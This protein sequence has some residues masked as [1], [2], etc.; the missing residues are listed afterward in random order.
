MNPHSPTFRRLGLRSGLVASLALLL[1]A[2]GLSC[3]KAKINPDK[4]LG[5]T[6]AVLLKEGESQLKRGRF[7]EG[8]RTLRLIEENLPSA[9]EFPSAKLLIA[10]SF[11]YGS[12]ASYPEAL[13]EYQSF[14]NYFP[15]HEMRDYALYRVALCH[16]ATIENAERDQAETKKALDA[17]Q[18]FLKEA[19]GSPYAAE[20]KAKVVQ[21]WRRMAEHELSIGIFYVKS[22][23]FG[24]AE[25]RLK[26]LLAT[27]PEYVD[28]ER[29]YYFLG[30]AMRKKFVPTDAY[31]A[32][33]KD[34][35]AKAQKNAVGDLDK[36]E[37][38]E[39]TKLYKVRQAELLAGYQAEAKGFYQKLVESYPK[40]EWAHRAKDRLIEMGAQGV[41][42][43]LDS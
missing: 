36:T 33:E 35:L 27:Y 6:A 40:S 18:A 4:T 11:F 31:Q 25:R 28:R 12:T 30:E 5:R 23:H 29:A 14:L 13:V 17:F 8:R 1:L 37:I 21:C 41:Q 16:Y 43:E 15:R 34:F 39:F 10:D 20:A 24:G 38:G 3:R 2:G 26:D 9:P 22:F 7:E 32:F 42:E 19:P